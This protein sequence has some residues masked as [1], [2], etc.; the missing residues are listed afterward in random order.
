[1]GNKTPVL[2]ACV[3]WKRAFLSHKGHLSRAVAEEPATASFLFS[4]PS[5]SDFCD[6][7]NLAACL[8]VVGLATILALTWLVTEL[9]D[10]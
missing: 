8:V 4:L 9:L 7:C 10:S 5:G 3:D 1:M 2:F 6:V